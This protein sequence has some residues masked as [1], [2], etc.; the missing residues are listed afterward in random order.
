VGQQ[1]WY[2]P[3]GSDVNKDLTLKAKDSGFKDKDPTFKTKDFRC[4]LKDS[5]RPRATTLPK[6]SDTLRLAR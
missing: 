1:N 6:G 3:K 2:Q 5:S 4:V